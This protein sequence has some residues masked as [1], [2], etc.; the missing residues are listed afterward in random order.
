MNPD[1]LSEQLI[2]THIYVF[3]LGSDTVDIIT[4]ANEEGRK[5]SIKNNQGVFGEGRG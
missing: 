1:R 4:A 2:M 5:R 3:S